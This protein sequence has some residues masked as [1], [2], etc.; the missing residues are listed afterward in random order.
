MKLSKGDLTRLAKQPG[1]HRVPDAPGLFLRVIDADRVHWT[2]RYRFAG[3]ENEPSLGPYPEIGLA[4]AIAK[5]TARRWRS[6]PRCGR[7]GE[8]T[9]PSS[10]PASVPASPCPTWRWK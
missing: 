9:T 10:F 8:T 5:H 7:Q 1:R 3:R 6:S 2:Y 4:E